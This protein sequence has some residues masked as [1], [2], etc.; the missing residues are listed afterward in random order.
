MIQLP[1]T[2]LS[3]EEKIQVMESL[4]D[5]LCRQADGLASPSWHQDLLAQRES[6]I[7]QGTEQ[8]EDWESAKRSIRNEIP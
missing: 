4:W 2:S 8:F 7:A 6:A 5:D 1:L 3:P